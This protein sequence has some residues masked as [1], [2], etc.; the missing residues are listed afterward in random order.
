MIKRTL[1]GFFILALLTC[2]LVVGGS[3]VRSSRSNAAIRQTT[4][5]VASGGKDSNDG[6]KQAPWASLNHAAEVLRAGETVYVRAGKYL[7]S[8]QIRAKNS[9]TQSAWIVYA[10]FPGEEV[11][12]D[13][14]G[15]KVPPPSGKPPFPH[16]QGAFQLENVSYV[17]VKG[18]KVI[19]SYSSGFTVR[20]SHHI[21]V[22]NNT[23][24]NSF[25]PGIGVWEGNHYKVIGNVVINANDPNRGY[26]GFPK[27][28]EAPHEAISIGGA[29]YFEISDNLIYNSQKEGIDVKGASQHGTVHDNH[30]HHIKRQGLYVDSW[31]GILEDVELFN[32]QVND[33]EGAGFAIAVEGGSV[34]KNIRVHH[35]LLYNNWGT[36]ILFG[37]WG[38]DGLR[39]A[40]KIYNNTVYRN[41]YGTPNPG[42][43]FYWITGGL[44]FFSTNL[45]N[46]EVRDNIFS[47]NNGFQIGYSDRYLKSHSTIETAFKQ[48]RITVSRN[49][50]FDPNRFPSPVYAGWPPDNFASIYAMNGSAPILDNP[51]FVDARVNNFHLK[52]GSPAVIRGAK[53]KSFIGALPP[54]R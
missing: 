32:N 25:S 20:N 13:A 39:E 31:D 53:G 23:S 12:L 7:L 2:F 1:V 28:D 8:Q 46:I 10:A 14:E 35:N 36:G 41:G 49:L 21:E 43:K 40:I 6:S 15:I 22:L 54:Q 11:I 38:V 19:N 44:Y 52:P 51:S 45:Q 4:Y 47:E 48:K 3:W 9:G 37:R 34:A 33:C 24:E 16:D 50:I 27:T 29:R 5:Y 18:L 26:E 30:I 42:E 17:R